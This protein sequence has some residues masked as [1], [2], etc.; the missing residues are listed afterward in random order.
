MAKQVTIT[1]T[2]TKEVEI[3]IE[4]LEQFWNDDPVSKEKFKTFD[5]LIKAFASLKQNNVFGEQNEDLRLYLEFIADQA[6]D[7]SSEIDSDTTFLVR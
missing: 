7:N 6:D 5:D 2:T 1:T 3:D 4:R